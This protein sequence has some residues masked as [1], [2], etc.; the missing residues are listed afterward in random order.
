SKDNGYHMPGFEGIVELIGMNDVHK[1]HAITEGHGPLPPP[2]PRKGPKLP[3]PI[4]WRD[5]ANG[6]NRWLTRLD[7]AC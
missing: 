3:F 7:H 5:L 1:V 4:R 6:S 2:P